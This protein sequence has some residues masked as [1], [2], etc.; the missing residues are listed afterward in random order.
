MDLLSVYK[1]EPLQMFT[2]L[3]SFKNPQF[4]QKNRINREAKGGKVQVD[5]QPQQYQKERRTE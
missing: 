1:C 2:C 3:M 5:H 4:L